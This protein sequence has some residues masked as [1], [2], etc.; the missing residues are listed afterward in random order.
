M[1]HDLVS[2]FTKV[3]GQAPKLAGSID[4]ASPVAL[5][6]A[7][8]SHLPADVHCATTT[9][10]ETFAFSIAAA[11]T[12]AKRTVVCL[13][14]ADMR[15]TIYAIYQFSQ[16]CLGVDPMYLWTDK[17]PDQRNAMVLPQDFARVYPQT[18]R[19]GQDLP[20]GD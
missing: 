2:D 18:I 4:E 8:N 6:I 16:S 19:V 14:G 3:F 13:T 1:R 11:K 7:E 15:G 12:K 20:G 10:I 17:Q 9:D 5:L